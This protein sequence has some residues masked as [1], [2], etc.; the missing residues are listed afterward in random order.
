MANKK[1]MKTE[2]KRSVRELQSGDIDAIA[3]YWLDSDADFMRSL[4]VDLAKM[5]SREQ[6]HSMLSAQLSQD[7]HE[8]QSY[9]I[10]WE[11]DG[12]AVGHSN[13][14]KIVFGEE[15]FM[16]LHI[17]R[18]EHRKGGHGEA[19]LEMAIPFFFKNMVTI[20]PV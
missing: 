17:W 19:F 13:V 10:I 7:Y 4:G 11:L 14:N 2:V 5:P 20:Q 16:H 18:Q 1:L 6:W 9:C 15:A 3:S 12:K 8:K